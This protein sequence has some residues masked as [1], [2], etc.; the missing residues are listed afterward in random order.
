M[1]EHDALELELAALKPRLPSPELKNRIAQQLEHRAQPATSPK[2]LALRYVWRLSLALGIALTVLGLIATR[3]PT[4]HV[5]GP[6]APPL[7]LDV[8][9]T[10]DPLRPSVWTYHRAISA[11]SQEID[12]LLDKH[13]RTA[14]APASEFHV[15]AF[16]MSQSELQSF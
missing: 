8:E 6:S 3:R 4:E 2:H 9:I 14:P 15:S 5:I 10:L 1:N 13:S 7:Q 11:E 12:A 16:P